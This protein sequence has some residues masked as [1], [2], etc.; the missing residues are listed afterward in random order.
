MRTCPG[1][2]PLRHRRI[3]QVVHTLTTTGPLGALARLASTNVRSSGACFSS[4]LASSL[5]AWRSITGS[6]TAFA[7]T[8]FVGSRRRLIAIRLAPVRCTPPRRRLQS[9]VRDG[10]SPG[11]RVVADQP[12]SRE[13]PSGTGLGLVAYSCGGSAGIERTRT[14]FPFH[15]PRGRTIAGDASRRDRRGQPDSI[16]ARSRRRRRSGNPTETLELLPW[17]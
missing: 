17:W 1:Q 16:K 11:S 8:S 6:H 4:F 2:P 13:I 14:G 7:A 10:R 12:P 5:A 15:L 9:T 3:L